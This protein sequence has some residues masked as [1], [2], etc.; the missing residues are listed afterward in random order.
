MVQNVWYSNGPQSHVTTILNTGHP[1]FSVFWIDIFGIQMVTVI[2]DM[3]SRLKG[4]FITSKADLSI[5]IDISRLD[6]LDHVHL[7]VRGPSGQ[8]FPES[9]I[10]WG[11]KCLSKGLFINYLTHF[12]QI[13]NPLR[14]TFLTYTLWPSVTD[15][16]NPLPLPTLL[17]LW[18]TLKGVTI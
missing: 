8:R 9:R 11:E 14:N 10:D 17:Q 5:S 16:T 15:K 12:R 7:L 4:R 1:H 6:F 13:C 3:C 2:Y 18:M